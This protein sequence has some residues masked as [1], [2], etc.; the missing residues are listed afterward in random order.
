MLRD[1][2]LTPGDP[3]VLIGPGTRWET[4]IWPAPYFAEVAREVRARHGLTPVLIGMDS[5]VALA[6]QVAGAGAINL[7]GRTS[8][9]EVIALVEGAALVL[10]HDSGPM[11]LATAFNKPMVALYGPTSPLRTGPYGRRD[12]VMRLDL[13]C[14]PCYLKRV[15]ECPN[16]HRCMRDMRPE[17]VLHRLEAVMRGTGG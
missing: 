10:M 4:K 9:S 5:E 16:G 2:G 15:S 12:A 11:H 7:A 6:D 13:P 8:L 14:S 1:E 3:Y 17:Q